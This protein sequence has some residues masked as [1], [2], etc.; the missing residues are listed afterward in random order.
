MNKI[1]ATDQ[2]SAWFNGSTDYSFVSDEAYAGGSNYLFFEKSPDL[3]RDDDWMAPG[4]LGTICIPNGAVAQGG[5]IY[6]LVGKNSEGKIVFATVDNNVMLPGKP[7]LFEATSTAMKFYYTDAAAVGEPDNSGAMKSTFEDGV[8]LSGAD[9]ENVYYFNGRALWSAAALTELPVVKNR[10][11]VKMDEVTSTSNSQAPGRRYITMGVNG[12]DA[13]TGFDQ[14][15]ASETPQ[16]MIIDGQLFILRGE[17]LYDA[18]GRL[19]K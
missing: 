12:K 8:V 9:L 11:Y 18:T 16:K 10:A 5:D 1:E 13:A 6:E 4:E 14:L 3:V 17:K 2:R 15:D 7:Y 19:V